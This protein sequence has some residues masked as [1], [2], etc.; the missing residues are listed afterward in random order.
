MSVA[1]SLVCFL[2]L[3]T[4]SSI[5][6]TGTTPVNMFPKREGGSQLPCCSLCV[7][8]PLEIRSGISTANHGP[9]PRA[10]R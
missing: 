2:V 9:N 6:F 1:T 8:S 7:I 5:T 3:R 4:N 10:I